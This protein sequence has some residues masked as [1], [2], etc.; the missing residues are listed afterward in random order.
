[1]TVEYS[2][3]LSLALPLS[4]PLFPC[5]WLSFTQILI[6]AAHAP[7]A[8]RKAKATQRVEKL[9]LLPPSLPA[10]LPAFST[11]FCGR[12]LYNWFEINL[13]ITRSHI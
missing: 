1:M 6:C 13:P 2:L 12:F 4:L 10:S 11:R 3:S 7:E 9:L 5:S 8:T